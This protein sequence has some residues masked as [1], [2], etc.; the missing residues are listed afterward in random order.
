MP[1]RAGL[2]WVKFPTVRSLTRVKCPGIAGYEGWSS[3][4][5]QLPFRRIIV[6]DDLTQ[7]KENTR[8]IPQEGIKTM[9]IQ[10]SRISCTIMYRSIPKPPIPPGQTPGHLTFLKNFGQ[11]PRYVASLDGQI[12]HPLELQRGSNPPP[13]R[14]NRIAYLWK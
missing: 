8:S 2:I 10:F 11:I 7:K 1:H 12:P 13:S 4:F 6:K 3:S 9:W 5:V 14:E